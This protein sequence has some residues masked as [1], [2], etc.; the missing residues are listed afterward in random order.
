[1]RRVKS[2][3]V[4]LTLSAIPL[5]TLVLT[6][7]LALA[8]A[9]GLQAANPKGQIV[10]LDELLET[11]RSHG[12]VRVIVGLDVP[13]HPEGNLGGQGAIQAQHS[14]I[15]EAQEGVLAEVAGAA[16]ANVTRFQTIPYLAFET[17]AQGLEALAA[18][19]EVASLQEDRWLPSLLD[20]SVPLIGGDELHGLGATGQGQAVA[21]LDTGV[22]RGH[23]FFGGRVVA[24]ACFSTH[25]PG[26]GIRTTCPNGRES[27]TG[28]GAAAP[29]SIEGCLHGTHVAGIAA[30]Q[31][32]G[33][34]GVAPGA[35]ILAVQVFTRL[36]GRLCTDF[37]QPS[38]CIR[39]ADSDVIEGLEWVFQQRNSRS[40]AAVNLSLGGGHFSTSCD[41]E[42]YAAIASNLTSAGIA[43]VAAAGNDGFDDGISSPACVSSVV[44][45][46]STSK[47]DQVNDFSNSAPILDLLAPGGRIRSAVPGGGFAVLDGTSMAAPHVAGAFA[48]LRSV[49]PQ[50]SVA[51]ILAAL[52]TTGRPVRGKGIVRPRID[53]AQA[54]MA[55]GGGGGGGAGAG[56][57]LVP[58]LACGGTVTTRNDGQGS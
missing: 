38:P 41:S 40:V 6:L 27:Q 1:M 58:D 35:S 46:G 54:A 57:P 23:P 43:V 50:A 53:V 42:S 10:G 51:E 9:V 8:G 3:C 5:R 21:I 11:A 48:L 13:F 20:Q 16:I 19:P 32:S 49:A 45:V 17:D 37:G 34:V 22:D 4:L 52:K 24:E 33:R 55:L 39:T 14:A 47:A 56:C 29:C 2:S 30:G 44:S 25:A 26:Q 31:G 12:T 36:E 7:V 15:R 28:T 18:S